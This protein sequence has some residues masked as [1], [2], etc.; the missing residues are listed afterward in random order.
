MPYP[1]TPS[2]ETFTGVYDAHV[3]RIYRYHYY[4]TR[5]R[6]TAEDLTSQTFLKAFEAFPRFDATKASSATWL[7]T[8]A[9]N[10]LIDHLRI[11][12]PS[13][14]IEDAADALASRE[15][16]ERDVVAREALAKVRD[17]LRILTPAQREVVLLRVWDGLAYSEIAAVT[18]KTEDACKMTFSRGVSTLRQ[19]VGPTAILVL[20]LIHLLYS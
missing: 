1:T 17:A 8:I 5:H 14:D 15:D 13:I 7:Y 4:R 6:E 11:Q 12:R 20:T 10:V 3:D 16:I 9:R 2:S 19:H 18:G